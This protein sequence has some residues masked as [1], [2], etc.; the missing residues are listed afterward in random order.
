MFK[1]RLLRCSFC[2]RSENEVAKLVAG[3]GV[4]ICDECVSIAND[5]MNTDSSAS[6]NPEIRPTV[7]K[8]LAARI[9][10]IFKLSRLVESP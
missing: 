8:K 3:P 9:E 6:A 2:R 4:Y 5:I 10:Q 1:L 7:W